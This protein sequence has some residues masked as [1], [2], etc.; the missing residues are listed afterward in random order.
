VQSTRKLAPKLAKKD[1][2]SAASLEHKKIRIA[3]EDG[4]SREVAAI[5][6]APVQ[7]PA[8]QKTYCPHCNE[9]PDGFHGEHELRRHIERTHAALRKVWICRDISS[10]GKFLANCKAC[11][12]GKRYGANY[13]AAAHLRRAHFNPCQKGRGGRGKEN[14]ERRGGKGGGNHPSMD[15]LKLWMYQADEYVMENG[16]ILV[17][18]DY[19]NSTDILKSLPPPQQSFSDDEESESSNDQADY[20]MTNVA[21]AGHHDASAAASPTSPAIPLG[22]NLEPRYQVSSYDL[23]SQT[24]AWETGYQTLLDGYDAFQGSPNN[25]PFVDPSLY[26]TTT[27]AFDPLYYTAEVDTFLPISSR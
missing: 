17:S 22:S 16:R 15:V 3:K 10:D 23:P 7:R 24:I 4:T 12:S 26:L 5:P 8:R 25:T 13:N 20:A 21:A 2:A 27:T 18:G 1:N 14:S 11:R 9:Q 6:K 19:S